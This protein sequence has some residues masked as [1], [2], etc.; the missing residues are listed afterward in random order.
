M[1]SHLIIK[2]GGFISTFPIFGRGKN[3]KKKKEEG[4]RR[5][6]IY[7][8]SGT[9]WKDSD[10]VVDD[11]GDGGDEEKVWKGNLMKNDMK[12]RINTFPSHVS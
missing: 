9:E 10:A 2:S 1:A 7:F 6:Y 4:E 8:G 12:W 3:I 11:D 5:H